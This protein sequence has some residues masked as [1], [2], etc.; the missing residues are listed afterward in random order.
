MMSLGVTTAAAQQSWRM[1]LPG[2]R[3]A[4]ALVGP[5]DAARRTAA[6]ALR[7]EGAGPEA[8][9]ALLEALASEG[10]PS[11]RAVIATTL[12]WHGD[13][14]TDEALLRAFENAQRADSRALAEALGALATPESVAGLVGALSRE[15]L[16]PA[17]V[18]GLRRAGPAAVAALEMRLAEAPSVRVLQLLGELGDASSVPLLASASAL[19]TA[20]LRIAALGALAD[21]GDSRGADA[22]RA[23]LSDAD[24]RVQ[25]AAFEALRA[26]GD[27]RDA[28]RL[29]ARLDDPSVTQAEQRTLVQTLLRLDPERGAARVQAWVTGTDGVRVRAASELALDEPSTPLLAVLY[30]LLEEGTLGAE[31]AGA[32]AEIAGG[33]GVGVL[34]EVAEKGQG[35]AREAERGL[36]V[37]IRAWG[38]ALGRSTVARARDLLR[39]RHV[40]A[41]ALATRAR[42]RRLRALAGDR[43]LEASLTGELRADDV[44]LRAAAA[45]DLM[46]LG[47]PRRRAAIREALRKER[48]PETRRRLADALL[49]A[50]GRAPTR[51]VLRLL[52]VE[53]LA[54][55]GA[56]LAAR[57]R[58]ATGAEARA[59]AGALR[60]LLIAPS[61]RLRSVAARAL[62]LRGDLRAVST[63]F[64]RLDDEA[65]KPEVRLACA[66][67]LAALPLDAEARL[68]SGRRSRVEALGPVR[69]ALRSAAAGVLQPWPSG[70]EVLRF[71]IERRAPARGLLV[72]VG[73]PDGRWRR[74]RALPSGEVF[75]PNLPAGLAEVRVGVGQAD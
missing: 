64:A 26:L 74:L 71:R 21:L 30:G 45:H 44:D 55:E 48:D 70:R 27:A 6:R 62:S 51:E 49:A 1:R 63:L 15:D 75:L 46:L 41:T 16:A 68:A 72:D 31:A 3:H 33:Q 61:P 20:A 54:A 14:A 25:Q 9:A 36:A 28:P 37:A 53:A 22:V 13:P 40:A 43:A 34:L 7:R 66:R 32:L 18:R 69:D 2:P 4:A 19:P 24:A 56:E 12:A 11:V 67:A 59:I 39:R 29:E 47:A 35:A 50:G 65:E 10:T 58:L 57:A 8:R 42:L 17:A 38:D 23:R 5:D 73:T 60:R 52:S